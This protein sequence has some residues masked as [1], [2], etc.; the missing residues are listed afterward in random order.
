MPHLNPT[1]L[2]QRPAASRRR[3]P[4]VLLAAPLF[5]AVACGPAGQPDGGSDG[6]SNAPYTCDENDV[7]V[8]SGTIT[9]DITLTADKKWLLRGGVFIGDDVEETV[10]TIEPGTTIYGEERSTGFLVI[11]RHSKIMAEG[12]PEA[13]I[14]FTSSKAPGSRARGDWGGLILNGNAQVNTG[15]EAYG[16]GGTGWY[17][18]TDD[19]DSSGVLRYVRVE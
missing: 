4:A 15:D 13:P 3:L 1:H 8:L 17:G 14:V 12:T 6:G 16:E 11:T 19:D 5:L 7:C 9:D 2:A 18:G 10:L